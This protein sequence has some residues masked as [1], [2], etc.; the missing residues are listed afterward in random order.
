MPGPDESDTGAIQ[1][2]IDS[3]A[4]EVIV[5]FAGRPWVVEPLRLRDRLTLRLEPGV[6][7][8]AKPGGYRKTTDAMFVGHEVSSVAIIGYGA[9]IRMRKLDYGGP[10]YDR[11][12]WRHGIDL[13]GGRDVTIEGLSIQ[14]TGG[15]AVYIG[16]TWDERRIPCHGITVRNCTMERNY[17]QGISIVSGEHIRLDNCVLRGTGG[18][19][20]QAGIDLEPGNSLDLLS[21]IHISNCAAIG[22]IG[23][24]FI[25]SLPRLTSHSKPVSVLFERC[26]ASGSQSHLVQTSIGVDPPVG[27][28]VFRD[29]VFED[30]PKAG[31]R[32]IWKSAPEDFS[33][34]FE[35]CKWSKVA[36][37]YNRAPFA[38]NLD[39]GDRAS[40]RGGIYFSDCYMFDDRARELFDLAGASGVDIRGRLRVITPT[41]SALGTRKPHPE[42]S[43][44]YVE[45]RDHRE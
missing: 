43:I 27:R 24:G 31:L 28:V 44:E 25:V 7:L 19:N 18:T 21:D 13:R 38:F 10:D 45:T 16:P 26:L 35:N 9:S 20:P 2:C 11:G 41:Q 4:A 15:D 40:A 3:G 42:L 14:E 22:N 6:R 39:S 17:R 36:S 34:H 8:E 23:S 5:P 37:N 33:L 32:G 12:E 29:C 30:T 1:R